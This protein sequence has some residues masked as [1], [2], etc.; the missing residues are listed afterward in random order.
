MNIVFHGANAE[1]FLPSV[2]KILGGA[3]D[4]TLVSDEL[5]GL[6]E[7]E[8]LASAEV[9][10]GVR[11]GAG[12]P[13]LSARLY[14]LPAAGYDAVDL[15]RLPRKCEACNCFGHE[16]AIAEY[17]FSALLS[18]HVPLPEA[19]A[20]LRR[21]DWHYWAGSPSGLRSELGAQAIGIIGHGHIGR[22]VAERA[23]VF[24][25]EVHVANRSTIEGDYTACYRLEALHEML[26]RVDIVLNTLPLT[27]TTCGLIGSAAF[28]AMRP[29]AIVMNVG[30]GPVIDEDALFDALAQRR[31]GG[32]II[33]TW[34][35]YP[36]QDAPRPMPARRPF[37]QLEN[38][39][40]TPHMSGWTEGTITRR[41]AAIVENIRRLEAGHPLL[42]RLP[43]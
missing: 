32:A 26:D 8:A 23:R 11:Y 40:M 9:V 21:G 15:A 34:Y 17:V 20:R 31:I 1:T 12:H 29:N 14:Q 3:H 6:G 28:A 24:G 19:D 13:D 39:T 43:R 41:A 37:H 2:A 42:N 4:I 18:R 30:R 27:D 10:V 5:S 25:M 22:T 33:D 36:T 7:V 38:V 16:V 35:S